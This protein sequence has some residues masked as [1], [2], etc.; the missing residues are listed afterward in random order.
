VALVPGVE[1]VPE[2]ER[3]EVGPAA[4]GALRRVGVAVTLGQVEV[5]GVGGHLGGGAVGV[6]RRLEPDER[7]TRLDLAAG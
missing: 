6:T 5:G 2:Q 4:G 1:V 7:G 3:G